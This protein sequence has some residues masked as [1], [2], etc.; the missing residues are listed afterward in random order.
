MIYTIGYSKWT[1][2]KVR[3]LMD[4]LGVDLLVDLRSTPYG[5]FNP[6]FNRPE[7]IRAFGARY[8]WKGKCLGGKPGP[9]TEAGIDWLVAEHGSGRT[10]LIMCVEH[11]PRNCHR[12]L[13]IGA[14][15]LVRGIDA[16]HLI[17]DGTQRTTREYGFPRP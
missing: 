8:V 4:D 12:L 17:H 6:A 5:R 10:L 3:A 7:L 1:V 14:R 9:A 15:L 16:V 13:D 2:E 11:D